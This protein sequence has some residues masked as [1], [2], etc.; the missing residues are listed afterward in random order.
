MKG[1]K[2]RG[3]GGRKGGREEG[4]TLLMSILIYINISTKIGFSFNMVKFP[5]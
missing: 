2:G 3:E 5:D 1:G 4:E